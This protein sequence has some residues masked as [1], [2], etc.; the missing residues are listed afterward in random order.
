MYDI[1][2]EKKSKMIE[3]LEISKL[4]TTKKYDAL[5]MLGTSPNNLDDNT[6]LYTFAETKLFL[7]FIFFD[8]TIL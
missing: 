4:Q 2:T 8:L 5:N 3:V 7:A 6:T 1:Y